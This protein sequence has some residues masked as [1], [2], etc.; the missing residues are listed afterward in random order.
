MS[1]GKVHVFADLREDAFVSKAP[2]RTLPKT[3]LGMG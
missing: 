1:R 3:D 2:S